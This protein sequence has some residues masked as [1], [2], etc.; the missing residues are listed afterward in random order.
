MGEPLKIDEASAAELERRAR[1][2]KDGSVEAVPWAEAEKRVTERLQ[3]I[4]S[5]RAKPKARRR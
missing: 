2:L 1:E 3:S 4:R 5:T